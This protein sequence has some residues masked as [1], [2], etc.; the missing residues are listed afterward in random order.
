MGGGASTIIHPTPLLPRLLE[1]AAA[2]AAA[3]ARNEAEKGPATWH[4]PPEVVAIAQ[5]TARW[6]SPDASALLTDPALSPTLLTL[7]RLYVDGLPPAPVP[8]DDMHVVEVGSA[9]DNDAA[10]AVDAFKDHVASLPVSSG[11]Y[12]VNADNA[13]LEDLSPLLVALAAADPGNSK[14][15][16]RQ[17]SAAGNGVAALDAA[18][19]APHTGL[20]H[21]VLG[22]SPCW[23][24]IVCA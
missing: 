20:T 7:L 21:L 24:G 12:A 3:A 23:T 10:A 4:L 5:D 2:A 1:A 18:A 17:L 6:S 9:D 13:G 11:G 8:D 14:S 15:Q 19:F 22:G 16:L